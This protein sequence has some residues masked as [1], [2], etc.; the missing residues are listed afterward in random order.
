MKES[1]P[2]SVAKVELLICIRDVLGAYATILARLAGLGKVTWRPHV[3]RSSLEVEPSHVW[4]PSIGFFQHSARGEQYSVT[5]ASATLNH[6]PVGSIPNSIDLSEDFSGLVRSAWVFASEA[7]RQELHSELRGAEIDK[8]AA[9]AATQPREFAR[10]LIDIEQSDGC[11]EIRRCPFTPAKKALLRS[12]IHD[13]HESSSGSG[14]CSRTGSQSHLKGFIPSVGTSP[15][16]SLLGVGSSACST[17]ADLELRIDS[18]NR[19]GELAYVI[20]TL[21]F[22]SFPE[23]EAGLNPDQ[24]VVVNLSLAQTDICDHP[25]FTF[26]TFHGNLQK[27]GASTGSRNDP[28]TWLTKPERSFPLHA[29]FAVP[30]HRFKQGRTKRWLP[31]SVDAWIEYLATVRRF[32]NESWELD[33]EAVY[34]PGRPSDS[35]GTMQP[36]IAL[37]S[38]Q[39]EARPDDG[40]LRRSMK[41]L[42]PRG[43]A[44]EPRAADSLS[45]LERAHRVH[46][47]ITRLYQAALVEKRETKDDVN[48]SYLGSAF[49][50]LKEW[51]IG[52]GIA[53]EFRG[54][55]RFEPAP[56]SAPSARTDDPEFLRS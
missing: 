17:Y 5:M 27:L 11:P 34:F 33:F 10:M 52:E 1:S 55:L 20:N 24:S 54:V 43:P 28:R 16:A 26:D 23:N 7:D 30:G 29:L 9:L 48:S 36:M 46:E 15:S 18:D 22:R 35:E 39:S 8:I 31:E 41:K 49:R 19:V 42:F 45:T 50:L 38:I 21:L 47:N 51:R 25:G 14:S 12:L 32:L 4:L 53:T 3:L 44:T 13:S 2:Q 40:W 56:E 6:V 37:V